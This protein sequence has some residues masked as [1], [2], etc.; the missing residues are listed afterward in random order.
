MVPPKSGCGWHTTAH[1]RGPRS[2][3]SSSS[4]SRSPAG[5][6]SVCDSMRRATSVRAVVG[7][8]QIDAEIRA[9]QKRHGRLKSVAVL[10]RNAHVIARD[11]GLNLELAVLDLLDQVASLLD[12]DSLLHGDL[13]LHRGSGRRDD[14]AVRQALQR[15]LALD[16][17]V[18]QD[19]HHC[20]EFEL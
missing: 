2:S 5:P 12:G 19:V 1:K 16:Q 13:L 7:E 14:L 3:G 8:L 11:G 20:L 15:D 17:F 6:A 18:L 4:A 9:A 10:A